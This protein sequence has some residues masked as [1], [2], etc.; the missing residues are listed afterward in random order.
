MPVTQPHACIVY[1]FLFTTSTLLRDAD[2]LNVKEKLSLN[3]LVLKGL[4]NST[5][6]R[7][8][9]TRLNPTSLFMIPFKESL[10]PEVAAG[11]QDLPLRRE[12]SIHR[13]PRRRFCYQ[14]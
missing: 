10:S 12:V 6:V 14:L 13:F 3:S 1:S 8:K 5:N 4:G 2:V 7:I 9:P 11:R